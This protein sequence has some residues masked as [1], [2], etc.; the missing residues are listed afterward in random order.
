MSSLGLNQFS[1]AIKGFIVI[2]SILILIALLLSLWIAW[3]AHKEV[4]VQEEIYPDE[5]KEM[6][7]KAQRF[8]RAVQAHTH[9]IGH[10]LMFYAMIVFSLS[11]FYMVGIIFKDLRA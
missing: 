5:V 10:I 3:Q 8:D 4:Q 6:V 7:E 9:F 11:I 1:V 2:Y